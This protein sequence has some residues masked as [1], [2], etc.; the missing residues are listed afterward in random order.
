M[1]VCPECSAENRDTDK[2]C[3]SC[4]T[5]I[6]HLA[7]P[8][9][10]GPA[11]GLPPIE[12]MQIAPAAPAVPSF[13]AKPA[14]GAPVPPPVAAAPPMPAPVVPAPVMAPPMAAPPVAAPFVPPRPPSAAPPAAVP[15]GP[16]PPGTPLGGSPAY[17]HATATT[18][19]DTAAVPADALRGFLVSFHAEPRGEFWPL[20]GGRTTIGRAD[21][22]EAMDVFLKDAT[23][24]SRHAAIVVD[25]LRS[26]V[27][28]EDTNSTNGTFVND[29]PVGSGGRRELK[30]GD[31]VRFGAF[32]TH[33]HLV[34]KSPA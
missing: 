32:V 18:A 7:P 31:R 23:V 20:R 16:V 27:M 26:V 33:V 6:A 3:N 25:A 9:A 5:R 4:G 21:S 34:M 13:S 10:V 15:A 1:I 22:G 19:P 24:S 11:P 2:F 30:A 28:L 8:A 17:V 14:F 29:E 12:Q